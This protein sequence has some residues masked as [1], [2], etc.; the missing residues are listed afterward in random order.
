LGLL[1]AVVALGIKIQVG[2]GAAFLLGL[3][4]VLGLSRAIRFLSRESD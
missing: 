4:A 1:L 3:L 2:F